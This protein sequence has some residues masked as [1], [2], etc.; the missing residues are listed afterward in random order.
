MS[1]EIEKKRV[2]AYLAKCPLG[3]AKLPEYVGAQG[4]PL[5]GGRAAR[6]E[7]SVQDFT[8][9]PLVEHSDGQV[10]F[11][12]VFLS[13]GVTEGRGRPTALASVV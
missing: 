4:S 3:R 5:R 8:G 10:I 2:A 1:H 7:G 12:Q 13:L 9:S 6:G 11:G